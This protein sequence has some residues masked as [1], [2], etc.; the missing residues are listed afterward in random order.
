MSDNTTVMA[1]DSVMAILARE[2]CQELEKIA[3]RNYAFPEHSELEEDIAKVQ[4]VKKSFLR[5]FWKVSGRE[6]VQEVEQQR[7]EDVSTSF[8]LPS[9]ELICCCDDMLLTV[10]LFL[11]R[12]S[13]LVRRRRVS[14]SRELFWWTLLGILVPVSPKAPL[15]QDL[16]FR[17]GPGGAGL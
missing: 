15:M 5:K 9:S 6:V 14:W 7:L 12:Q 4:A 2:G 17:F 8:L 13:E 16:R 11:C 10:S 3:A 1:C